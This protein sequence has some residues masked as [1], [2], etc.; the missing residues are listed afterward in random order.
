MSDDAAIDALE[1]S[2][3]RTPRCAVHADREARR[4][5]CAR[6]GSYACEA[7]FERADETLCASCRARVGEALPWERDEGG[8]LTRYWATLVHV[9]PA[10]YTSFQGIREGNGLSSALLFAVLSNLVSYGVPMLLCAP[11]MLG[12]LGIVGMNPAGPDRDVP[13]GV[14]MAT[15]A[16]V[17]FAIPP[18]VAGA[19]VLAS[20]VVGLLYHGAASLAGGVGSLTESLRAALFTNVLA[21]VSAAAWLLGRIPIL[22]ILVT[23]ASYGLTM[24]WQTFALAGHAHGVHRIQDNRAW[25]VA[26]VPALATVVLVVGGIF[27]LVFFVFASMGLEEGFLEDLD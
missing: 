7:C 2:F 18:F 17:L 9:L 13:T 4:T 25:L 15:T 5:P 3:Q 10:P 11:C 26:A 24:L 16:C 20:L 19:Q 27:L 1:D 14:L 22:G 8:V 21:P 12:L 6:C 23:L